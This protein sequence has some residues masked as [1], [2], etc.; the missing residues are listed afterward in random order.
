MRD[1]VP[2]GDAQRRVAMHAALG[3]PVRLRIVDQLALGDV[4]PGELAAWLRIPTNLLTHHLGVLLKAG[5]IR[6]A[7]SEGDRRRVYVQLVLDDP[8]VNRL[9]SVPGA[10]PTDRVVFVCTHNSARSQLAAA[11]WAQVSAIPAASAGTHPARAIHARAMRTARRHGLRLDAARPRAVRD[12]LQPDD[13][14]VAVCDNAHEALPPRQ[15][16][17]W[18]IPDPAR[19]DTTEAFEHAYQQITVRVDRLAR[20]ITPAS[21]LH[22]STPGPAGHRQVQKARTP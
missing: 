22:A 5:L 13:L 20:S 7:R 19:S 1:D 4:S 6:R 18:A 16:L 14:V 21:A 17:H 2:A 8:L 15:G 12:V 9:V 11:A 10:G 3:E